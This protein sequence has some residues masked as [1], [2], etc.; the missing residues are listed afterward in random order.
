[1]FRVE[2]IDYIIKFN[3]F[4]KMRHYVKFKNVKMSFFVFLFKSLCLRKTFFRIFIQ[5]NAFFK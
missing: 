5:S 2:V 1:M 3:V 4:F